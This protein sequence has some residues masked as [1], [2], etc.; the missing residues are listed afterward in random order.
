[1]SKKHYLF[2]PGPTPVPPSVA[3]AEARPLIHHR[4]AEFSRLFESSSA[5]LRWLFKTTQP[6]MILAGSGTSAMEAALINLTTRSSSVLVVRAGK[7][8]E[9]WGEIAAAYGLEVAALD[10]PWG[11]TIGP[12]ELAAAL[13]EHP[14]VRAVCLTQV[15]S[16]TG[17]VFDIPALT[18]ITQEFGVLSLVDG[19]TGIGAH[20]FDFDAWKVDA[21]VC[22]SQ[23]AL[24]MPPGLAFAA[25]SERA[26]QAAE[27]CDL[28][29][30]Y[31]DLR[32]YKKSLQDATTPFTPAISLVAALD[33]A[34]DELQQVGLESLWQR[35]EIL[36]TAVRLGAQ[37]L[38]LELLAKKSPCNILTA[39]LAPPG[40]EVKKLLALLRGELGVSF[41]GGQG[42]LKGKVIR[43][44]HLG[45][46]NPFDIV[47]ALAALE[48]GLHRLGYPLP[49]GAGVGA[50]H[51]YLIEHGAEAF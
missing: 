45:F 47:T 37:A 2:T 13:R 35:H 7:F 11:E 51:N 34:L 40:V 48:T 8:G 22:G 50:A 42:P 44:G 32:A 27:Q 17:V 41:V 18:Q 16:S 6:V 39:I 9:R 30:Y 29:R 24:G 3:A 25:L 49:I 14:G 1:M 15:E 20:P 23:K 5:R 43:I 28:P 46:F 19:I 4:T 36:A 12:A 38:G 21:A 33:Q 10:A 31:F 26:W